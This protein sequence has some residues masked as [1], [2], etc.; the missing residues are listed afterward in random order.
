MSNRTFRFYGRAVSASGPA[1]ITAE[2]NGVQVHSG[3]VTTSNSLARWPLDVLFEYTGPID[4]TGWVPLNITVSKGQVVFGVVHASHAGIIA[5]IDKSTP[6]AWSVTVKTPPEEIYG[7][8]CQI[9]ANFE[10]KRNVILDGLPETPDRD[11]WPE[12]TGPWYWTISETFS[13]EIFVD[14]DMVYTTVPTVEELIEKR[15]Q[16][17][18]E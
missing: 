6:D 10:D 12:L 16:S 2:F 5:E 15:N 14:P 3:P 17:A 1:E 18:P 4:L 7:P 8:V 9:D 11:N 13:C